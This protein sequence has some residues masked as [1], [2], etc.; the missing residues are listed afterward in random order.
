MLQLGNLSY[1]TQ[2][3]QMIVGEAYSVWM[4]PQLRGQESK[5]A[6]PPGAAACLFHLLALWEG[7]Q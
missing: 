1:K 3:I 4:E 5:T 6:P 7:L 2:M